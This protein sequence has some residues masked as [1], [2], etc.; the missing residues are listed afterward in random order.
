MSTY[1]L[2]IVELSASPQGWP[3][4][5]TASDVRAYRLVIVELSALLQGRPVVSVA[6]DICAYRLVIVEPI[7]AS[8][9][10]WLAVAI[11]LDGR[12]PSG[13]CRVDKRI[14]K[15][16]SVV[17]IALDVRAY[18]LAIVE[19]SASLQGW[20]VVSIASDVRLPFGDRRANRVPIRLAG[21]RDRV[22]CPLTVW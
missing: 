6:S 14:R 2:A 18:S 5:S 8:L 19:L 7:S 10:G 3:V 12:L 4:V 20:P 1:R 22:R 21:C 13:D 17:A 16:W 15:G 9:H 11:A